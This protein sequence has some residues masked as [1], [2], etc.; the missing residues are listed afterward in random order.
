MQELENMMIFAKVLETGSFSR[1]AE[2]LCIAKSSVSKKVSDLER[3]LGVRL[4]QRSTRKL[5][6]TEEGETLYQH[7]LQIRQEFETAKQVLSLRRE[8]PQGTLKISVSPL[9]GNSIIAGLIPGFQNLYPEV[10]V[11]LHYSQQQ[12]DLI[13]EGYD[14]SLRMGQLADSSMVG[15]ELFVVKSILCASPDYLN[16]FGRPQQPSD[17]ERHQYIRW[18]APKRPPYT[19]LTFYKGSREYTCNINSRFSTDD[20][21]ASLEAALNGGG[22]VMLPN[23]AVYKEIE[24]GDL[25]VLLWD[26]KTQELPISLIYP[27]RKHIPPKVR[28]F[29]E[30]LKQQLNDMNFKVFA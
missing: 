5:N 6:V 1:T 3:E 26:Y 2:Q 16:Q 21:Q 30:F 7:C 18:L 28:V 17:I 8:A 19:R 24:R 11:E 23:Y 14:L 20:A 29:S 4:I 25:E 12:A 10:S 9:F 13:G 15:V 22:L 27:Q